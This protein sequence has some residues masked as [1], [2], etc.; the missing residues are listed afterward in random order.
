LAEKITARKPAEGPAGAPVASSGRGGFTERAAL[1]RRA[2]RA[3]RLSV[4]A[5]R[6]DDGKRRDL[7]G[8]IDVN[9]PGKPD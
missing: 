5:A 8:I 3:R 2:V 6:Q 7:H 9:Q 1:A 4:G